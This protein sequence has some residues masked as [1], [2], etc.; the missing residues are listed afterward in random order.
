MSNMHDEALDDLALDQEPDDFVVGESYLIQTDTMW[1]FCGECE[2]VSKDHVTFKR[3]SWLQEMGRFSIFAAN[4]G[5]YAKYAEFAGDRTLRVAKSH[6]VFDMQI[7]NLLATSI[8][9]GV[10]ET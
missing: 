3:V 8:N 5:G 10:P 9:N 2:R 1:L 6:V 4:S 7:D